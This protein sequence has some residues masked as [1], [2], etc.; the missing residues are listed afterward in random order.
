MG[1]IWLGE[2]VWPVTYLN[3]RE[4]GPPLAVGAAVK[5]RSLSKGRG[6]AGVVKRH[7]FAGGPKTHGQSDRWR[8]PGSIGSTTS[9]GRVYKGKKMAGRLGGEKVTVKTV[10]AEVLEGGKIVAVKG[11][12]PGSYGGTV[13]VEPLANKKE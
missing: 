3:L 8:A 1:Q 11:A 5:V 4:N 7:G 2:A 6:F 12:V 9:P 13:E 10:V